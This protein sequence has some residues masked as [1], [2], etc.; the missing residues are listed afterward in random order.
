MLICLLLL[1]PQM[2]NVA[3]YK[4]NFFVCCYFYLLSELYMH[5]GSED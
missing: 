3:Y 1:K 4:L 5:N 2:C